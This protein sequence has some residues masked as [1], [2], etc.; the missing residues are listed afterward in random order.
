MSIF[1]YTSKLA[2]DLRIADKAKPEPWLHAAVELE[3]EGVYVAIYV[4]DTRQ[5][6]YSAFMSFNDYNQY[7]SF[8]DKFYKDRHARAVDN[9]T[10]LN[11]GKCQK[12]KAIDESF[13]K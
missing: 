3:Q 13:T 11:W 5:V 8:S 1:K 6:V 4:W 12:L 9:G 10:K 2:N 7:R